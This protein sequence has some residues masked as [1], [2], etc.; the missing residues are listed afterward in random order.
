[1]ALPIKALATAENSFDSNHY[2]SNYRVFEYETNYITPPIFNIMAVRLSN[3]APE[4][5]IF[6]EYDAIS[7]C[8]AQQINEIGKNRII[9]QPNKCCLLPKA[10]TALKIEPITNSIN[11]IEPVNS[12]AITMY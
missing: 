12:V 8:F 2:I 6:P 10:T 11:P 3:P 4:Y 5:A 9:D 1:L 7:Q